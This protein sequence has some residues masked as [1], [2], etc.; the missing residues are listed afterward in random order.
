M[1]MTRPVCALAVFPGKVCRL[2]CGM[3]ISAILV[4]AGPAWSDPLAELLP[5]FMESQNPYKA[6]MADVAAA[7]QNAVASK[8]GFYPTLD[9]TVTVGNEQQ[10]K[11]SAN[12]TNLVS[13]EADF[14]VTQR[15][16]D[17]GA[18]RSSIRSAQLVQRQAEAVLAATK[19]ALLLRAVS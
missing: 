12:D 14:S 7:G 19:S 5:G 15:L 8:G 9:V 2:V 11:P 16:W 18:T 3:A 6:A 17:N 10:M 1:P 13:R 4:T